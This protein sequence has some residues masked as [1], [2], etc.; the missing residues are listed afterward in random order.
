MGRDD[1]R[2]SA[3][4]ALSHRQIE[5]SS[6]DPTVGGALAFLSRFLPRARVIWETVREL[7]DG[8]LP[9]LTGWESI[10]ISRS[11]ARSHFIFSGLPMESLLLAM[12]LPSVDMDSWS[13]IVHRTATIVTVRPHRSPW[14][15]MRR[16]PRSIALAQI[17]A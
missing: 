5:L 17:T 12:Q 13:G 3:G 1:L 11:F 4:I 2:S 15:G 10:R 7:P 6:A 14:I 9:G 8:E 16:A